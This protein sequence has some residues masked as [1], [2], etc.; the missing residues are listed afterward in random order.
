MTRDAFRKNAAQRSRYRGNLNPADQERPGIAPR[1]NERVR[2]AARSRPAPSRATVVAAL[3]T[4]VVVF[5]FGLQLRASGKTRRWSS[6]RSTVMMPGAPMANNPEPRLPSLPRQ[7]LDEDWMGPDEE[8]DV[9]PP[10]GRAEDDSSAWVRISQ[11][12]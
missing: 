1:S 7:P 3:V 4:G 10:T 6:Q 11:S 9:L 8:G 12:K 2:I 5:I